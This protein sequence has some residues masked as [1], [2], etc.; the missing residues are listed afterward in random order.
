MK[1]GSLYFLNLFDQVKIIS[2]LSCAFIQCIKECQ[3]IHKAKMNLMNFCFVKFIKIQKEKNEFNLLDRVRIISTCIL[4]CAF[5]LSMK[6]ISLRIHN[7]KMNLPCSQV[8]LF[9][10]FRKDHRVFLKMATP[11]YSKGKL[12]RVPQMF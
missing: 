1:I 6:V 8:K 3:L 12:K 9:L 2:I 4:S 10:T 5:I 7:A 11:H